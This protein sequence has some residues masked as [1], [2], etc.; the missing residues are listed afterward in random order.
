MNKKYPRRVRD[1]MLQVADDLCTDDLPGALGKVQSLSLAE[2]SI[3]EIAY[4]EAAILQRMG[5][6]DKALPLLDQLADRDGSRAAV[7]LDL[8]RCLIEVGRQRDALV[9]LHANHQAH[10]HHARYH[11]L[12]GRIAA[13]LGRWA[14]AG[15]CAQTAL[16]LDPTS[17]HIIGETRGLCG[18]FPTGTQDFLSQPGEMK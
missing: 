7:I 9:V 13:E 10:G 12:L 8:V 14:Q 3:D 15:R 5:R 16:Q 18:L 11:I 1:V 4:T 17:V 6:W 2:R